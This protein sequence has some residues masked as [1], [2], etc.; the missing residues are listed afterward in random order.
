MHGAGVQG[1]LAHKK[2]RPPRSLQQDYAQ[3]PMVVSGGGVQ[4]DYTHGP[5]VVLAGGAF[6]YERG[7]PIVS[8]HAGVACC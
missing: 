5:M 1:Y 3:G 6:S 2:Q 7:T 4:S 8:L